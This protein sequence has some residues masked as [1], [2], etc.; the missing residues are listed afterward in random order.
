MIIK[1]CKSLETVSFYV[2]YTSLL[3]ELICD[4]VYGIYFTESQLVI[5]RQLLGM[6]N[7]YNEDGDECRSGEKNEDEEDHDFYQ[8]DSD[9]DDQYDEENE[10]LYEFNSETDQVSGL[11]AGHGLR[12]SRGGGEL[13]GI[14]NCVES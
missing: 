6:L 9:S 14:Y 10:N 4:R 2:L 12:D 7:E 11:R 8:Y 13:Y 3:N 5:I 1:R